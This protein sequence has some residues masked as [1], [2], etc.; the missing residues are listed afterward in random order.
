MTP[1]TCTCERIWLVQ[2]LQS[3]VGLMSRNGAH[4]PSTLRVSGRMNTT[5]RITPCGLPANGW[6]TR[7]PAPSVGLMQVTGEIQRGWNRR[8]WPRSKGHAGRAYTSSISELAVTSIG[9]EVTGCAGSRDLADVLSDLDE[10]GGGRPLV[11]VGTKKS[12]EEFF[13]D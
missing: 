7:Y 4:I 5:I 3:S 11:K 13:V 9:I 12:G 1:V 2:L 10:Q 8:T 6:L